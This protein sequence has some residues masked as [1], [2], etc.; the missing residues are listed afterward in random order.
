MV[1]NSRSFQVA[2]KQG[3][4]A[5]KDNLADFLTISRAVIGLTI[6]SLSFTGKDAYTTVVIL[7]FVGAATDVFDGRAARKYLGKDQ[8][9]KLG[10]H[11]LTADTLFVLCILTYFSLS[12]I[13]VPKVLGLAW[14][15]LALISG[16]VWKLKAKVLTSFEIP[17]TLALYVVAAVYDLRLFLV[18]I[19]PTTL[20][21][22]IFNWDRTCY[23]IRVKIPKDFSE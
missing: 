11:D 3:T 12:S 22:V 13:V 17:T 15:G 20:A 4:S 14:T 9:G 16:L 10:K 1:H 21:I 7:A 8:E 6:L 5:I 2:I 23:V 19:V 18:A